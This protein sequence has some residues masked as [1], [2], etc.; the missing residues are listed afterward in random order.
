MTEEPLFVVARR[1]AHS[2]GHAWVGTEHLLLALLDDGEA[3]GVLR[4]LGADPAVARRAIE[5][6]LPP[7]ESEDSDATTQ[8]PLTPCLRSAL[9][10]AEAACMAQ[11]AQRVGPQHLLRGLAAVPRGAAA[12]ALA[13][14]GFAG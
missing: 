3:Q 2:S 11:G 5:E 9:E 8:H 14:A 6:L 13:A 4:A 1:Y 10:G 7:P 12:Q